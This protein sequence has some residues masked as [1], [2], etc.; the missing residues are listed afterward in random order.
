MSEVERLGNVFTAPSKTFAEIAGGRRSWWLPFVVMCLFSYLLFGAITLKVSWRRVAENTL[1]ADTATME[2]LEQAP[3]ESRAQSIEQ[4]TRAMQYSMMG[5]FMASPVVILL[6]LLIVAGVLMGTVNFIFGGK[7][8]FSQSLAVATFSFVP[9]VIKSGLGAAVTW[10]MVPESFN[11]QNFAPT[12][13][14]AF[15]S[16]TETSAWLYKLATALDVTTIW[17][18]VLLGMGFATI[19]KVKRSSGYIAVFGWWGLITAIGVAWAAA[20]G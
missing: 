17:C 3:P 15:L 18:M 4:V 8:T 5:S 19:G 9:L 16:P 13:I 2:R 20:R 1:H 6:Q 11:L 14:G 10:F 7:A 12:S